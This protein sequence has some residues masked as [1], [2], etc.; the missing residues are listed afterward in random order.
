MRCLAWIGV[1]LALV[2]P[3]LASADSDGY[4]CVGPGYV[5]YQF[6]MAGPSDIPHWLYVVRYGAGGIS[7]PDSIQ[8]PQ[9]QVHG[10]R[11]RIDAVDVSSWTAVHT[12]TLDSLRRPAVANEVPLSRAGVVPPW[13][14]GAT[15]NFAYLRDPRRIALPAVVGGHE[16]VLDVVVEPDSARECPPV[17]TARIRQL[18]ADG[19]ARRERVLFRRSEYGNS[20]CMRRSFAPVDT[21]DVYTGDP[22]DVLLSSLVF[23]PLPRVNVSVYPGPL[24]DAFAAYLRRADSYRTPRPPVLGGEAGMV[25]AAWVGYE[26]QL[27][28]V[29]TGSGVT[30]LA[31]AYVD[32]LS[33]CYEWE[34]SHEC[35]EEEARFADEYLSNNPGGPFSAY[36]PLLAAHRWLC[37][38]EAFEREKR[39]AD[40]IR[41]RQ[42]H[43][44]RLAIAR[45][46]NV[47]LIRSAADQ[48]AR[49]GRCSSRE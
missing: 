37:A 20:P 33:P 31:V 25:D 35:P 45:A 1:A 12:V 19:N 30:A 21:G 16:Y 5:A 15:L 8:L 11:C 2:G 14:R 13:A 42:A 49:R 48:L 27:A 24:R 36:L 28:A 7:E 29:A 26:R 39:P 4:F 43:A 10:I 23:G 40:A 46:S 22:L 32:S 6:G 38:A 41:S 44:E 17:Y 18:D 9:F 47:L 3:R 34:G